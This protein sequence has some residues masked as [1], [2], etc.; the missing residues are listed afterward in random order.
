MGAMF[1]F[2]AAACLLLL[3]VEIFT[4][5]LVCIWFVGGAAAALIACLCGGSLWLQMIL[6]FIVS[7]G[8][9]LLL[10]PLL[11]R[12]C[13]ADKAKT[14]VDALPG[15]R[16]IVLETID[17]LAGHGRIKVDGT[18][19]AARSVTEQTIEAGAVVVIREIAG[20]RAY[21]EPV[22]KKVTADAVQ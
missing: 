18:D 6:F 11:K 19:W 17:N 5:M 8:L 1:W 10:R 22:Q 13:R 9:L 7:A 16:A 14:N 3:L 21:V 2:W 15:K 12:Q 4:A 20:V